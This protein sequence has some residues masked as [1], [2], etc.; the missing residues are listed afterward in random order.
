MRIIET[1]VYRGPH[2]FSA[3]PMVRLMLA[4]DELEEYPTDRLPGFGA[5]LLDRLPG[6]TEH[7][8]SRGRPGGFAE[9]LA[10]GTWLG[11]VAEHVALELQK[12]AGAAVTRGKTR[13]VAG[14]PGVYNV[15]Y[16]YDDPEVALEAGAAALRLVSS[17]LPPE[18]AQ[19]QL[20][21]LRDRA[22]PAGDEPIPGLGRLMQV[23]Q[24]R[25]LGPTTRSLAEAARR[26][27]IPV[28]RIEGSSM[29]R[30]GWGMRQRM[31]GAS[32][33]GATS[34][35]AVELAGD[36]QRTRLALDAA[37]IPVP[38]GVV[39]RTAAAAIDAVKRLGIPVVIKPLDG[40]H[41]RGVTIGVISDDQVQQAF[42]DAA[43]HSSRVIVEQQVIGRDYRAL[44][45]GGRLAA[46]AER[47]PA[48][49]IGD[50]THSVAELVDIVNDDPRRGEGHQNV[51][52]RIT[53]DAAADRLLAAQRLSRDAVPAAGAEVWLR[54]TANI[55]T[56]GEAVDRTGDVHPETV[57]VLERAAQVIGLD[58]AG[59]DVLSPDISHP[60]REVGGGII[61]VNAAPGFRMHLAPSAGEPRD[62][63]GAVIDMFYRRPSSARIPVVSVTGTNGKST[64]VRMIAHILGHAGRRVGMTTT[65]GVYVGGHL[66]K[67]ADASGPRS[68][69]MLLDDPTVEAAVLE[70]ARG[71]ILR[72]GLAV[73]RADVGIMLNVSADH[74]GLGGIDSLEQLARVKSVVVRA[75][76]RRGLSILNAD[77]PLTARFARVAGGRSGFITMQPLTERL[78]EC[79]RDGGLVGAHEPDGLLVLHDGDRRVQL[80]AADEI[81]ATAGGA[82]AFN[83]QNALAAATAAFFLGIS[84]D[85]IAA[86]L[87]SFTGS[88]EQ[89][90]GRFNL[91][92]SPGFT[93]IV[94]YG[95][96][97][98]AIAALGHALKQLRPGHDRF[99]GVVSTPGDRRDEDIRELGRLAAGIFDELVFRER[100]DGRGREPGDVVRRLREGAL[101]GGASPDRI[102]IVLD[103]H[104]A[105]DLA[106]RMATPS[107]L[108]VLLPTNVEGTWRQVHEFAR[109][110]A[111][112]A[113]EPEQPKETTGA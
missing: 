32:L 14:R 70:T 55:S 1:A 74:L 51:L 107:D 97:P 102:R 78:R 69:R 68:A 64:T 50:G 98:A 28:Q 13:S 5:A 21:R 57:A 17:L 91:T 43:R 85:V 8:C 111:G 26:R 90:P 25:R 88:F 113:S 58:V 41:G 19:L 95:H 59:I 52:T 36:K 101:A 23:A 82:A 87:R 2:L 45:I 47:I 53:L 33:T 100:P 75:V 71:G 99:I 86:A 42:T 15:L 81:P 11:H 29:L 37:G 46:V 27:G 93:T 105:M 112:A 56:G 77:D 40:N 39:V 6:L 10:D 38:Q 94:D 16:A 4:L 7:T 63:A 31:L 67:K 35:L 48:R 9:R 84:P 104:A 72:E 20:G 92:R 65:S 76:S 22:L 18:H 24:R 73:D 109:N 60:L 30:L 103:E 110:C 3:T 61:E 83:T 62:V 79:L 54:E 106:L 34:H 108:V 12:L 80:L 96:N 44:V 89:N 66:V 49:V